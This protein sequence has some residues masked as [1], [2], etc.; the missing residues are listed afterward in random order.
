MSYFGSYDVFNFEEILADPTNPK[1]NWYKISESIYITTENIDNHPELPWEWHFVS[2]NPNI[3]KDF[4]FRNIDKPFFWGWVSQNPAITL[5][6]IE[7]YGFHWEFNSNPDGHFTEKGVS[8]NPN[9]TIDFVI[10]HLYERWNWR[11]LSENKAITLQDIENHPELIWDWYGDERPNAYYWNGRTYVYGG[12]SG[13]E[14]LTL[15]FVAKHIHKNWDWNCLAKRFKFKSPPFD[16][17]YNYTDDDDDEYYD[18]AR[19]YIEYYRTSVRS[20]YIK[21]ELVAKVFHPKNVERWLEIGSWPLVDMMFG[22]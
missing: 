22:K 9:L 17:L 20:K 18:S 6:D 14:D 12:I 19:Y 2:L 4:L 7:N 16:L 5:K 21:E 1:W 3:N 15:E 8:G 10:D 13:R 11:L